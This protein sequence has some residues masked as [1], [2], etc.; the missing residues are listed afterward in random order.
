[1]PAGYNPIAKE[2]YAE[3]L[4]IPPVKIWDKGK[5][6]HDVLNMIF[7]NMRARRDQEGDF[8]ALIG[9]ARWASAISSPWSTTRRAPPSIPASMNY[10]TWPTAICARS[11]SRVRTARTVGT[12]H[13]RGC[14]PW[15]RRFRDHRHG[16]DSASD[17]RYIAIKSP[18]QVPYFINSY[19]GNS[20][21]GVYLGL[22][23]FAALP[24]PY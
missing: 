4:R 17:T 13:P 6:R 18:P 24:P 9:A 14:W 7:T 22:M 23:M 16:D 8:N 3:C 21:S 5:P 11:S 1:M 2:I 12:G 20:H 10:S 15:A 19:E